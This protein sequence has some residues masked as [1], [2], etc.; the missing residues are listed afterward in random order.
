MYN[1]YSLVVDFDVVVVFFFV[2]CNVN[3]LFLFEKC[4]MFEQIIPMKFDLITAA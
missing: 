2:E 3:R 1:E 4:F